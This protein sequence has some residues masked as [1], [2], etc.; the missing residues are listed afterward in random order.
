ML[1]MLLAL[2]L[3]SCETTQIYYR[4]IFTE[5]RLIVREAYPEYLTNQICLEYKGTVCVKWDIMKYSMNDELFRKHANELGI[6]CYIGGEYW[7]I[8]LNKPGFCRRTQECIEQYL[9]HCEKYEEK[10]IAAE[11]HEFLLRAGTYCI[12]GNH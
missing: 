6:R 5:Q 3:I 1:K 2:S 8:C 12:G 11:E 7:R 4:S 10:Y 9:F